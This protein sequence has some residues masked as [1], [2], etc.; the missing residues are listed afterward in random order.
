MTQKPIIV[1]LDLLAEE[2][3]LYILDTSVQKEKSIY[4]NKA[5]QKVKKQTKN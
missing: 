3:I 2:S 1:D 5:S 4:R